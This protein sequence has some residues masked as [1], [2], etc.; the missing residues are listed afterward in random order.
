[1]NT[2]LSSK[3][4]IVY[5]LIFFFFFLIFHVVLWHFY[6][7][8]IYG[9]PTN[10]YVGDLTRTAYQFDFMYKRK[11]EYTLPKQH[12]NKDNFNNQ[13]IDIITIG[14][15]FSNADTCGRNPYYQDYLATKYNKN[16][17]NVRLMGDFLNTIVALKNSGLLKKIKP[18]YVILETV[19][20]EIIR[21]YQPTIKTN[22]SP[23]IMYIRDI[24]HNKVKRSPVPKINMINDINYKVPYY[25]LKT[26]HQHKIHNAYIFSLKQQMFTSETTNQLLV[27]KNDIENI[28]YF[29]KQN[30]NT[31]NNKLN[32]VASL[33]KEL[34]IK[35][36]FMP[37]VD[38]YNLYYDY[39]IET[40][41]KKNQFFDLLESFD[42][43][44]IFVNT[45]EILSKE[46]QKGV[47]D[48]YYPDDTHWSYKASDIITSDS[49]FQK[50]FS[51]KCS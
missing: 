5:F 10:Y 1:M 23:K 11:L 24:L 27:Y 46:L 40:P 41:Y 31:L 15:S 18:K 19:E 14:D 50:I 2:K 48:L 49:I 12:I 45:Q 20:R 37:A 3:K 28:K 22:F 29:T 35:L 32:Q 36:I 30:V 42:K 9:L 38:K 39:I 17:M 44:Y 26:P 6:T 4:Y 34:D 47:R 8:K 51:K 13:R 21:L 25:S 16:I 7:S 43:K 33:L